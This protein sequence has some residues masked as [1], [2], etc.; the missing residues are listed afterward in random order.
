MHVRR[1]SWLA[2]VGIVF[3]GLV[4][5]AAAQKP[6]GLIAYWDFEEGG[7]PAVLDQSGNG[8]DGTPQGAFAWT[9]E[10]SPFP[11]SQWAGN[12]GGAGYVYVPDA[13]D[14]D[15]TEDFTLSAWI[16]TYNGQGYNGILGKHHA[17]AGGDGS[18]VW[19]TSEQPLGSVV[20]Y[21]IATPWQYELY[22]TLSCTRDDWYH[23]TM[24]YD[25]DTNTYEYWIH[26]FDGVEVELIGYETGQYEIDIQ[27]ND[28]ELNVG[29]FEC[30][31]HPFKGMLDEVCMFNRVLAEDEILTLVRGAPSCT[32]FIEDFDEP[33][34]DAPAD[35][36]SIGN[37]QWTVNDGLAQQTFG[38]QDDNLSVLK[39]RDQ[40]FEDF[41][42]TV[43]WRQD[44]GPAVSSGLNL[45]F[46]MGD[47]PGP[48]ADVAGIGPHYAVTWVRTWAGY[49]HPDFALSY[50]EGWSQEGPDTYDLIGG[51]VIAQDTLNH[52]GNWF[53][54]GDWR[55]TRV[56]VT[57]DEIRVWV[58]HDSSDPALDSDD[59]F[60][61][62]FL[63]ADDRLAGGTVALNDHYANSSWDY[64]HIVSFCTGDMNCDGLLNAFDID[65]FTLALTSPSDY[66]ALH[67]DCN[68]MLADTNDDGV[69]NAFD[70]DPFVELLTGG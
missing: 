32:P 34:P 4:S 67:P 25:D 41:E 36:Q 43:R 7:G 33:G 38:P 14:L 24:T 59:D 57:G 11:G 65:P 21:F 3:A 28:K 62:V 5:G 19:G 10:A 22:G 26:D 8:H 55:R 31:G 66:D 27:N 35:W 64:V 9:A 50:N 20:H 29:A 51:G 40:S 13:D 17:G 69:L 48:G 23:F 16:N 45:L 2:V 44:A 60:E 1:V 39:L 68:P 63:E 58:D 30:G 52:N 70:I 37:G 46:R 18:W 12:C 61:L 6:D 15:P 42:V 53:E 49:G 56:R 47:E 54:L